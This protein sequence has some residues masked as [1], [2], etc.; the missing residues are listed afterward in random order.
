MATE[1]EGGALNSHEF[2]ALLD[3]GKW[4]TIKI[5]PTKQAEFDAR[6]IQYEND[7]IVN[8]MH[9]PIVG[10]LHKFFNTDINKRY[11]AIR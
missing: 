10:F 8:I 11:N 2:T 4:E 3:S 6:I 9:R 7:R 5:D 1:Y